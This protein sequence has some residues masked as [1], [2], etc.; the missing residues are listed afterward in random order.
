MGKLISIHA[1]RGGT[2]KTSLIVN[3]AY[4]LALR[5][6][7]I[8]MID[9]DL[10][11]PGLHTFFGLTPTSLKNTLNDYLRGECE[12]KDA[13]YDVTPQVQSPRAGKLILV[14][15]SMETGAII[16]ILREGYD[17][18]SLNEGCEDLLKN[19]RLD[20]LFNDTHPGLHEETLLS[21]ALSDAM[22]LVTRPD[23]QDMPGTQILLDI[24]RRM[25]VP[26]VFLIANQLPAEYSQDEYKQEFS[27]IFDAQKTMFVP[28]SISLKKMQSAGIFS[29]KHPDD[30]VTRSMGQIADELLKLM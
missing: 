23:G 22:I 6:F 16:H 13:A 9:T 12:I 5:G 10:P 17:V 29:E 3:L 26:Q 7:R 21:I 25:D 20:F 2:G 28:Y 4:Q 24:A 14:P 19:Y 30:P 27:S 1:F 15:C 18:S 11:S 8:G